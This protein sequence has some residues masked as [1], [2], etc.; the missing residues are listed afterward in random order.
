MSTEYTYPEFQGNR[1]RVQGGEH[2][3]LYAT[4]EAAKIANLNATGD[5][6]SCF[7]YFSSINKGVGSKIKVGFYQNSE[8]ETVPM[9]KSAFF[10][11]RSPCNTRHPVEDV[12]LIGQIF[13][14]NSREGL[15]G[16]VVECREI[17]NSAS[18]KTGR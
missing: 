18:I 10:D 9:G 1:N 3:L 2:V 7:T 15:T 16:T 13:M 6:F 14:E 5:H 8:R 11:F 17:L 12:H 4:A